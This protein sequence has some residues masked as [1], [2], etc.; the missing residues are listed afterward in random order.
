MGAENGEQ[1]KDMKTDAYSHMA[2]A[3]NLAYEATKAV[4]KTGKD[5]YYMLLNY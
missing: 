2:E 4:A 1:A 5:I 3:K